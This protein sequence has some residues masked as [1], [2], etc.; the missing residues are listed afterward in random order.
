MIDSDIIHTALT[1]KVEGLY[2]LSLLVTSD[3][4]IDIF[5]TMDFKET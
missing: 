3:M 4:T 1:R 5:M 2:F